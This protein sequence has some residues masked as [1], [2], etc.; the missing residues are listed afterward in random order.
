MAKQQSE[1]TKGKWKYMSTHIYVDTP[2]RGKCA[3]RSIATVAEYNYDSESLA[4]LQLIAAAPDL[5]EALKALSKLLIPRTPEDCRLILKA[6]QALAKV[7]NPSA[8]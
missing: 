6:E 1:Y 7:D 4:N 5:Y 2:E 8:L 3:T